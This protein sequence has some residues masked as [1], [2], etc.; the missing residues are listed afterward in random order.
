MPFEEALEKLGSQSIVGSTLNS[1]DWA[2]IPIGLRDNAFFSA[3][4]E[5]VRF[6]QS[7]QDFIDDFLANRV[8]TLDNGEQGLAAGSR[9]QFVDEMQDYCQTHGLG[10]LDP[11]L[12]GTMQDISSQTRLSLIFNTKVAQANSYGYWK[13]GMDPDVL[14]E[15]P[16]QRFIRVQDV[17]VKRVPHQLNE[18]VVKLKTDLE[19]WLSMNDESFGGFGVPWGPW[20][21]NSG[22]GEQDEDRDTAERLGLLK[23]GQ[24]LEPIVKDVNDML[25]ASTEGLDDDMVGHLRRAF[26]DQVEFDDNAVKWKGNTDAN[27]DNNPTGRDSD[28]RDSLAKRIGSDVEAIFGDIRSR[29]DGA[30]LP[31]GIPQ[32]AGAAISAVASGRKPL[33]HEQWGPDPSSD[34]VRRLWGILPGAVKTVMEDGHLYVYRPELAQAVIDADPANYPGLNLFDKIRR[35]TLSGENGDL[36]GYGARSIFGPDRVKVNI[37]GPTGDVVFGF[38]STRAN[39]ESSGLARAEDFHAAFDQPFSYEVSP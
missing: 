21:F 9:A 23:P 24:K 22:M 1:A 36:L 25:Q 35:A 3:T 2:G 18:G 28:D 39:A 20:G 34:L 16:A 13:Q 27:A 32:E 17:K 15:F 29:D 14:D 5:D 4:I 37:I 10:P 26:G 6:L 30:P 33:Y 7:A 11:D 8:V 12:T 19:F 31:A 38:Y